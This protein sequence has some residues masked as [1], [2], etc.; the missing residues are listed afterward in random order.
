[1]GFC[2]FASE[3]GSKTCL[4]TELVCGDTVE[5]LMPFDRDN[6]GSVRVNGMV[7]AF[8]EQ[9]EAMLLEVANKI[10]ALD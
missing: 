7:R 6:L 9:I 10:N 1:L 5:L 4:L 3:L 2:S 8:P